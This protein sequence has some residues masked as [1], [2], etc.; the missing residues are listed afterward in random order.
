M[1]LIELE[2]QW[3]SEHVFM[4]RCP[5][6]AALVSEKQRWWLT[7]K[8]AVMGI[9]EQYDL[10]KATFG[11]QWYMFVVPCNPD[12]VWNIAGSDFNSLTIMPSLNASDSGHAHF[13]ISNG[14]IVP[15]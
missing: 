6:C 8:N 7:C 5:H 15:V 1:R 12:S 10:F 4:M 3:L 14:L 2:P 13:N 11:E 9:R